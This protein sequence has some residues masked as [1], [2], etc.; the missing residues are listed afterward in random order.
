MLVYRETGKY[1]LML[2]YELIR[3][4]IVAL[5]QTLGL[6]SDIFFLHWDELAAAATH[7]DK[8]EAR[9]V[10]WKSAQRLELPD[11]IDSDNLARLG[12]VEQLAA[13]TELKGDAVA[14][15]SRP[16]KPPSC[17]T[18]AKPATSVTTTSLSAQALTRL[19]AALHQRPRPDRRTRWH[20]QP[21]RD[22]RPRLRH[23]AVVCPNATR[24]IQ[25]GATIRV[26]GNHGRVQVVNPP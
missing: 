8:I 20:S 17:S 23:P 25:N 14:A 19:D 10:R 9:K 6:G 15:A 16:G 12:E 22:C 5:G 3:A 2:G 11:V 21:R 7:R 4:N 18:R 26:D 1:Y 24:L 13:A